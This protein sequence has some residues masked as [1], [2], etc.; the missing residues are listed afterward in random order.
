MA[1]RPAL[2]LFLAP[3]GRLCAP[4]F[5]SPAEEMGALP[6]GP[7]KLLPATGPK[8]A[9][10][11]PGFHIWHPRWAEGGD[12]A[13]RSALG[14]VPTQPLCCARRLLPTPTGPRRP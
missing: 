2:W 8:Q 11:R 13:G 4:L 1:V 3:A 6:S 5:L 9:C 12:S 7:S 14:A 10:G